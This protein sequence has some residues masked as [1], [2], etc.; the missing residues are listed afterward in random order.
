M[1][2]R[3]FQR[4]QGAVAPHSQTAPAPPL[5]DRTGWIIALLLAHV[6]LSAT[7]VSG[8]RDLVERVGALMGRLAFPAI[9]WL[10]IYG[11]ASALGKARRPGAMAYCLFVASALTCFGDV[12]QVSNGAGHSIQRAGSQEGNRTSWSIPQAASQEV[13]NSER[14]GLTFNGGLIQHLE[15]GFRLPSPGPTFQRDSVRQHK[16]DSATGVNAAGR[17]YIVSWVLS[18]SPRQEILIIEVAKGF[19]VHHT[20]LRQFANTIR[21]STTRNQ[22]QIL[23]DSLTTAGLAGE[24]RLETRSPEGIYFQSRCL[25]KRNGELA[26]CVQTVGRDGRDL[27]FVRNGLTFFDATSG[28]ETAYVAAMKSDLRNLVT[29]EEAYFGDSVKYTDRYPALHHTLSTGNSLVT[30]KL[31]R[32]GW[33]AQLRNVNTVT[34]CVVFIG[35][36][37]TAPASREGEPQCR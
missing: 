23:I 4:P 18:S 28:T 21:E 8:S 5:P 6:A 29:A 11:I 26:V 2:A 16:M 30:L 9:L 12:G 34:T 22:V 35:S 27:D 14:A 19:L 13:T 36:T 33:W 17:K 20:T 37:P 1:Q 24:Y 10:I 15:F 25:G 31:T 32:D 3:D 7:W